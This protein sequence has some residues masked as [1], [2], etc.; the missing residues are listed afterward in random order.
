MQPDETLRQ[1]AQ[2]ERLEAEVVKERELLVAALETEP[3][4]PK[5]IADALNATDLYWDRVAALAQRVLRRLE[6]G[7]AEGAMEIMRTLHA[8]ADK[9]AQEVANCAASWRPQGEG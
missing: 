5:D 7:D 1:V 6:I 3:M 9:E 8:V 4:E 2:T